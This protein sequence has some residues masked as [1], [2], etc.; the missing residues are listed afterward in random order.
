MACGDVLSLEDLQTA[1]KHQIFE[2]EVI[3][4]KAGG[5]AGG[6]TIGTATNPVTGQTQ[7]TLPSILADLGFDVQ[8][9]TSST[10]G[11]LASASQVFLNDTSGSLGL[12]DYYA[13]GGPFP[14]TV[15]AGTDPALVGSGYIMRPSR[16]AGAQARE[17]LRRSY[18]EAGYNL[19][20]GS[21]EAGGTLV[22]AN[23]V[24]LQERT[25][26]AF[27]G[28]AG[29]V[30]AGTNP[31]SGGF[32]D[33][34]LTH[35]TDVYATVAS[36][37]QGRFAVGRRVTVTDRAG[38]E[39]VV[40]SGGTANGIDIIGAGAGRTAVLQIKSV[41][42]AHA[43]GIIET[44]DAGVVVDNKAAI[45]RAM[46][47]IKVM[48]FPYG[49]GTYWSS[50]GHVLSG[51][52]GMFG[53]GMLGS[54]MLRQ[55]GNVNQDFIRVIN[56]AHKLTI[57]D[58]AVHGSG[59]NA[60]GGTVNPQFTMG[61]R[62]ILGALDMER[63]DVQRFPSTCIYTGNTLVDYYNVDKYAGPIRIAHCNVFNG[64]GDVAAEKFY[65]CI[66]IERSHK[67]HIHDN[68]VRGGLSSIRTQYYCEDMYIH[69]NVSER[70][71]GDVGITI[72]L[73][74]DIKIHDNICR[75]NF[76][77]G[78]EYDGCWRVA[79]NNNECHNNGISGIFGSDISPPANTV[80]KMY[81]ATLGA[82]VDVNQSTNV[83]NTALKISG[84]QVYDHPQ[85]GIVMIGPYICE[86]S[87]V[88]LRR[89]STAGGTNNAHIVI[90]TGASSG[91]SQGVQINNCAGYGDV[92]AKYLVS[93]SSYQYQKP[94]NERVT[95][96]GNKNF[97]CLL[98]NVPIEDEFNK[99]Q[100]DNVFNKF[101]I[102]AGLAAVANV[103][104]ETPN[105]YYWQIIDASGATNGQVSWRFPAPPV[106]K[107]LLVKVTHRGTSTAFSI[108]VQTYKTDSGGA[109][110]FVATI[111]ND[112]VT[113]GA[114]WV[115]TY[116][117]ITLPE[118]DNYDTIAVLI[119][120]ADAAAATVD[121]GFAGAWYG[122]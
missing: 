97:A 17:A 73:S 110:T 19:V 108:A 74:T 76:R 119:Q 82:Y 4:G 22:N 43:F 67:V 91:N 65:D 99:L 85:A 121:I 113:T 70:A 31:A 39:F 37:A 118:T 77:Y 122:Q 75:Y 81:D 116:R 7:Q 15:P 120:S 53:D 29:P 24:L 71:W 9:W 52:F 28:P 14:K 86:I 55:I 89:N 49:G 32:I 5:V 60:A 105:G 25:G 61:I 107:R 51:S 50:G 40:Q 64:L 111:L 41:M 117:F 112:T 98:S 84:G 48:H 33:R 44:P 8:P 1:K 79:I 20:D 36:L 103:G 18:A 38:A 59:M 87:G 90:S 109:Q 56:E 94:Y 3:T 45:D 95:T 23:D 93:V 102:P 66:R 11:V 92:N 21:F 12:G 88:T 115:D 101:N 69:D 47:L 62:C 63:V 6:A 57:R 13:W 30:A 80:G 83:K 68:H 96:F 58:M 27:S 16:L 104:S 2:A 35:E 106:A 100:F 54:T 10:G 114:G 42:S 46:T 78:I 26:K 34:S 72:A